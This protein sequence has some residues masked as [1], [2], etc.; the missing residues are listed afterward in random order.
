[1]SQEMISK[2]RENRFEGFFPICVSELSV[3]SFMILTKSASPQTSLP[4]FPSTMQCIDFCQRHGFHEYLG[5]YSSAF[6]PQAAT[7]AVGWQ[8]D[9]RHYL[10]C[11]GAQLIPNNKDP[12]KV[13]SVLERFFNKPNSK[14]CTFNC[15]QGKDLGWLKSSSLAWIFF[16]DHFKHLTS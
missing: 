3:S 10:Q 5:L 15:K 9:D 4:V 11:Y 8:V 12:S 1:M 2:E 16:S 13:K 14:S 7:M 6:N